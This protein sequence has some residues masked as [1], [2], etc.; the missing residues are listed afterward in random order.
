MNLARFLALAA[1]SAAF[2]SCLPGDPVDDGP[3]AP[4]DS[5]YVEIPVATY[6]L[7]R[8]DVTEWPWRC[9]TTAT[10]VY[11]GYYRGPTRYARMFT[12]QLDSLSLPRDIL[13]TATFKGFSPWGPIPYCRITLDG[14]L[15]ASGPGAVPGASAPAIADSGSVVVKGVWREN[16]PLHRLWRQ[17]SALYNQ[18]FYH[19]HLVP[20]SMLFSG[21][22]SSWKAARAYVPEL[23][24]W[25]CE[26][27]FGP[28]SV[29]TGPGTRQPICRDPSTKAAFL[30]TLDYVLSPDYV[31]VQVDTTAL[32][33]GEQK[34]IRAAI[35]IACPRP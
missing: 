19:G 30:S 32:P 15:E 22:R 18:A 23:V 26:S 35:R 20:D 28:D 13:D 27:W 1:L 16:I 8:T 12:L 3:D 7:T 4:G 25:Q 11:C 9:D 2:F 33:G 14:T 31:L 24:S 10:G 34:S 6:A 21:G 5:L 29:D 17:D